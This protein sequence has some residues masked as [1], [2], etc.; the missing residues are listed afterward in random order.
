MQQVTLSRRNLL[1]LLARLEQGK[2]PYIIK[3]RGALGFVSI[4]V[5]SDAEH[6]KDRD[7]GPMSPETERVIREFECLLAAR[8]F[9]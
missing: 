2:D 4:A 8:H 7:P 6:Y 1:T 3:P 5:E 9:L